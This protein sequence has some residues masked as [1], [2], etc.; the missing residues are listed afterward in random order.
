MMCS[1]A[2]RGLAKGLVLALLVCVIVFAVLP[3][4]GAAAGA[5]TSGTLLA[6]AGAGVQPRDSSHWGGRMS[7]ERDLVWLLAGIMDM[8]SNRKLALT[9]DQ[10]VLIWPLFNSLVE[11]DLIRLEVD[12]TQLEAATRPG[13]QGE[14]AQELA[15]RNPER[16]EELRKQREAR[17]RAIHQVIEQMEKVLSPKQIAYVDNFDF[18]P[19]Q[20]GLAPR[21][22]DA[23]P[24]AGQGTAQVAPP[25]QQ[26]IKRF[27][28]AAKEVAQKLAE[29]Y[30]KFQAFIQKKA[31]IA[32]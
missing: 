30:K 3:S 20:Y 8:E 29:F 16:M 12:L 2:A 28:E 7:A 26:Q 23:R 17:E 1:Q 4:S 25:S 21:V 24:R 27:V 9:R 11:K 18:D 15:R 6:Q 32:S 22:G 5:G 10:A 19:A 13:R 31:G 14:A